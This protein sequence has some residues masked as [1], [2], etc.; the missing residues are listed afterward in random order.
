[1]QPDQTIGGARGETLLRNETATGGDC[2]GNGRIVTNDCPATT[3]GAEGR[4][5]VRTCASNWQTWQ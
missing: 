5:S 1:M 2:A 4:S 3:S